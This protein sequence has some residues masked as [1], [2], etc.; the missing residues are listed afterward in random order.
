M[1]LGVEG[2]YAP[3]LAIETTDE[4]SLRDLP[5][6]PQYCMS[7]FH[8]F[9]GLCRAHLWVDG[10]N[11]LF[12]PSQAFVPTTPPKL[13]VPCDLCV[14]VVCSQPGGQLSGLSYLSFY[15]LTDSQLTSRA[16]P[17]LWYNSLLCPPFKYWHSSKSYL[18]P[19]S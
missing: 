5:R 9:K 4:S 16:L 2:S 8:P 1:H 7:S 11:S 19:S 18:L 14:A 10:T 13:K 12:S 15:D 17:Q 6:P 3:P